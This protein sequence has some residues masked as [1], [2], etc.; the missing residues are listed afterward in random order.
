MKTKIIICISIV[1]I[2][3]L[4]LWAISVMIS[5]PWHETPP[6]IPTTLNIYGELLDYQIKEDNIISLSI[7]QEIRDYEISRGVVQIEAKSD[8]LLLQIGENYSF[9]FIKYK[10]EDPWQL[11]VENEFDWNA[12]Y[13]AHE[14]DLTIRFVFDW[15]EAEGEPGMAIRMVPTIVKENEYQD[16]FVRIINTQNQPLEYSFSAQILIDNEGQTW[17]ATEGDPS[18]CCGATGLTKSGTIPENTTETLT[19]TVVCNDVVN[20][21]RDNV[22]SYA[23]GDLRYDETFGKYFITANLSFTDEFGKAHQKKT[24]SLFF[25]VRPKERVTPPDNREYMYYENLP[26]ATSE[27]INYYFFGE[28]FTLDQTE[29]T[30]TDINENEMALWVDNPAAIFRTPKIT[31]ENNMPDVHKRIQLY[32]VFYHGTYRALKWGYIE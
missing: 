2:L 26:I 12:A 7:Q 4:A 13:G 22:T 11:S 10:D 24:G 30:W 14:D 5:S 29:V 8:S 9:Y 6:S 15:E 32:G 23:S 27:W 25:A 19:I 20:E 3:I 28:G 16:F 31:F 17:T 18:A 21:L 1:G